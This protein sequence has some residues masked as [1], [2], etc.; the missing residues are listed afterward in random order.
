MQRFN[1]V[2]NDSTQD[3]LVFYQY[4]KHRLSIFLPEANEITIKL[5]VRNWFVQAMPQALK[6][7][8]LA[9]ACGADDMN[10]L[11]RLPRNAV[12]AIVASRLETSEL[13]RKVQKLTEEI[14]K[15]RL[16][17]KH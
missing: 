8:K 11:L 7:T 15:F 12:G 5:L 17:L 3:L 6:E 16:E 9:I 14:T 1:A 2:Q 13:E 4:L 10:T